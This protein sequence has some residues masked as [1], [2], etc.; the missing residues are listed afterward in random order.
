MNLQETVLRVM[1]GAIEHYAQGSGRNIEDVRILI[2]S[3][4]KESTPAYFVA[5]DNE[6]LSVELNDVVENGSKKMGL[7]VRTAISAARAKINPSIKASLEFLSREEGIPNDKVR[8][9]VFCKEGKNNPYLYLYRENNTG[10]VAPV[11]Q[12]SSNELFA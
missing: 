8:I 5:I 4:D 12:V 3:I 1:K 2:K 6:N 11:K 7:I 9:L 10:Q